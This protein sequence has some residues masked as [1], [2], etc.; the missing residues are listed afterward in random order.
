MA[1]VSPPAVDQAAFAPSARTQREDVPREPQRLTYVATYFDLGRTRLRS[2]ECSEAWARIQAGERRSTVR[3]TRAVEVRF[4]G[5][6]FR[7]IH[8][9]LRQCGD[10]NWNPAHLLDVPTEP[11][12]VV[13]VSGAIGNQ[14]RAE[15]LA[16]TAAANREVLSQ[17]SGPGVFWYATVEIG[18]VDDSGVTLFELRGSGG[19]ATHRA[20][21]PIRL[22]IPTSDEIARFAL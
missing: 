14:S 8:I 21:L 4:L 16:E 12:A 3:A 11:I 1:T 6:A 5:T 20:P 15:A 17:E 19:C 18:E 9:D 7:S 10:P 13:E 22:V 2:L